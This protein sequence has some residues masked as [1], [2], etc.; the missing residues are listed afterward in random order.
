MLAIAPAAIMAGTVSAAGEAL[1]RLPPT[2]ARPLTWID[3]IRFAPSTTPGHTFPNSLFSTSTMQ[4]TAAPK[5]YAP[6]SDTIEV[7]SGMP[8]MS[9]TSSGSTRPPRIWISRS[10]PP[11]STLACPLAPA[12]SATA[13]SAVLGDS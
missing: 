2:V 10:V 9:T 5:R 7:I 13:A 4:G 6:L 1:H 12:S 3:P 8:L 11:A